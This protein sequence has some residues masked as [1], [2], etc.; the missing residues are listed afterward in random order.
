MWYENAIAS[1]SN[2][3]SSF[4]QN[5]FYFYQYCSFLDVISCTVLLSW[6]R[7]RFLSS[8]LFTKTSMVYWPLKTV[9]IAEI[10]TSECFQRLG[11]VKLHESGDHS[12]HQWSQCWCRFLQFCCP[13][14]SLSYVN[15][16]L[17]GLHKM[18]R[19]HTL[20]ETIFSSS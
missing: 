3:A 1:S 19:R 7:L 2:L 10:Y 14:R 13:K 4:G 15:W 6:L 18:V 5:I 8:Y 16:G 11:W 20:P 17:L 12:P 9:E